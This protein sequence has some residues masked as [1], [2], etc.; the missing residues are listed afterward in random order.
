VDVAKV[1]RG[2]PDPLDAPDLSE[3]VKE[4]IYWMMSLVCVYISLPLL[5]AYIM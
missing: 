4:L 3:R 1:M 5:Y 2:V